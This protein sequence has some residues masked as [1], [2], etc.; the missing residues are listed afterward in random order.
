MISKIA[1]VALGLVLLGSSVF[2]QSLNDAKKAIDAEQYQKAKSMLKNLTNTQPANDENH[3]YLGW[4]YLI[5]DYPD[6][7]KA[8]FNMGIAANPKSGLNYAGLGAVAHLS[9]DAAGTSSNFGLAVQNASKKDAK[10][11]LYIGQGY[12]MLP[13]GQKAVTADDA[14]AAIA[15]LNKGK[16][17]N[18]KD[19]ELLVEL[20]NVYRSQ[21]NTKDAYAA[22]NDA[23]AVDPKSLTATVAEGIL[24]ENAQ[25]FE[26]AEKQ[27]QAAVAIDPNF[28]P[29][30]REWAE[31]DLYWGTTD[32]SVAADK[33]KAALDHYQKFMSLTDNSTESLLRYADFLYNAREFKTLQ[34]VAN[35]LSKSAN[36]NARVYRYIGYA[37]SENK[38]YAT[39]LTAMNNWFAKAEPSRII[40]TDYLVLGHL[41]LASGGDTAKAVASLEKA[42]EMDTIKTQ[43]IYS[44]IGTMYKDK[45][46]YPEMA[47][48][49]E[50]LIS[51]VH[52]T[53]LTEHFWLGF[54]DYFV[55]SD[56]SAAA[57]KNP[58][59]K[60]DSSLLA[61]ADSALSYAQQKATTPQVLFAQYRSYIANEKDSD[62]AHLK[63]LAKPYYDQIIAL[64]GTK[65][66][67]TAS[68]KRNL[69]IAYAYIGNYYT[70]KEKDDA[71][72]LDYFTKARDTDPT[73]LQAK[74]YF[75]NKMT[76][77]AKK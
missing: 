44:E 63:G 74:F 12:L 29:A 72:A 18:P 15:A 31:T 60:P 71:K 69:A 2:A 5:Q 13:P 35:T 14:T 17:Q 61:R 77:P 73:N 45:K 16:L 36:S 76:S 51:K 65:T 48:I 43:A 30:Y 38:D 50:T 66:P 40:S 3:F 25:N 54:A 52:G 75:D 39:G 70:Y 58:A 27:F 62:F 53:L 23:L 32:K 11:Y 49:Y 21:R 10:V 8:Q 67:L 7:A 4:V 42:A 37:A 55:F 59:I 24:W 56:Q 46:K 41:L 64:L 47:K 22:Y 6:S 57:K 9:K 19:V 26:D 33:L 1:K 68:E 20:G 28:G 34:D